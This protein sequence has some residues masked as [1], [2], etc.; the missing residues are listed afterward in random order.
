MCHSYL[1]WCSLPTISGA[2]CLCNI[3]DSFANR[4]WC[5]T[6]ANFKALPASRLTTLLSSLWGVALL[7]GRWHYVRLL[8]P[9]FS[10]KD[11]I[12]VHNLTQKI[13]LFSQNCVLLR[14]PPSLQQ[15]CSL[16]QIVLNLWKKIE[17]LKKKWN[18]HNE[19]LV[20]SLNLKLFLDCKI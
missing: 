17:I 1:V 19:N 12:F 3:T 16:H 7:F 6:L 2:S 9:P 8:R 5:R 15:N 4:T 18:F 20:F 14:K 13:P 10:P 11:T